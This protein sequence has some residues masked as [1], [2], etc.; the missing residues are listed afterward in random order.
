MAN[1]AAI[2]ARLEEL[3]AQEAHPS[4]LLQVL[5]EVPDPDQLWD[6]ADHV[7]AYVPIVRMIFRRCLEL[8]GSLERARGYLA[9]AHLF[10]GDDETAHAIVA[11]TGEARD[12]VFLSAW[13]QLADT[14]SE[15]LMRL[16]EALRRCP[17][18][19]RLGAQVEEVVRRR[20]NDG[21]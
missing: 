11:E 13:A 21:G 18:D 8:G 6:V 19:R 14:P 1:A 12:P 9:L 2:A 4:A 16:R 17:G 7:V 20:G 5:R 15:Q 3:E 10:D